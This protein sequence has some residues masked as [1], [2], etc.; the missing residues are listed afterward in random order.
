MENLKRETVKKGVCNYRL[1]MQQTVE[2]ATNALESIRYGQQY[3]GE[4]ANRP[5]SDNTACEYAISNT[6]IKS[7]RLRGHVLG[8]KSL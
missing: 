7:F 5:S 4:K 6:G 2:N 3:L 8:G 1:S